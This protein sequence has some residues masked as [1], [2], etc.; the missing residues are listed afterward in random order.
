[1]A[2][3]Q[4][5]A[6]ANVDVN[7]RK[8]IHRAL[9]H[10]YHLTSISGPAA[11]AELDSVDLVIYDLSSGRDSRHLIGEVKALRQSKPDLPVLVLAPE[12]SAEGL[13][14]KAL[15]LGAID[16]VRKPLNAD[17]LHLRV[18]RCL[19]RLPTLKLSFAELQM[20]DGGKRSAPLLVPLQELHGLSGR[21]DASKIAKYMNIPL[22]ALAEAL[23]TGYTSLHKTP[24]SAPI[25]QHLSNVKRVLVI[26]SEMLGKREVV[27]AWLNSAHP[28]LGGR[29]PLSVILEG[30]A[31]AVLTMIEN[32]L[33]GIAS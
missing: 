33:A 31:D 20:H 22:A 29:T 5:L 3:V 23:G 24:D 14:S 6:I 15:D 4:T 18:S 7:V 21:L 1:M 13:V 26:L 12:N 17:E 2:A 10:R 27:L 9:G 30:H 28:D 16:F 8:S 11:K 32:A 25:Q 19:R